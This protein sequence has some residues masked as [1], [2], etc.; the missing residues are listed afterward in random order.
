MMKVRWDQVRVWQQLVCPT[1]GQLE[2]VTNYDQLKNSWRKVYT[3][4]H[5]HIR[6]R[7]ELVEVKQ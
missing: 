2:M 4:N 3:T 1:N 5:S 6:P 7:T